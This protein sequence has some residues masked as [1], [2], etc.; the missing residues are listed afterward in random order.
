[1]IYS[2]GATRKKNGLLMASRKIQA[3][4]MKCQLKLAVPLEFHLYGGIKQ[5][6]GIQ[7]V[8]VP[9]KNRVLQ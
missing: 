2:I 9:K 4:Q 3:L 8:W 7:T 1:M 6:N 5:N